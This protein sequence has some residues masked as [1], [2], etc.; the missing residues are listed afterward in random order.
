MVDTTWTFTVLFTAIFG[1]LLVFGV[2][3]LMEQHSDAA[4]K[5]PRTSPSAEDLQ[6][7]SPVRD[8]AGSGEPERRSEELDGAHAS[9]RGRRAAKLVHS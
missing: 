2:L 5:D 3:W 1:V 7:R 9:R 4:A 8:R 6:H